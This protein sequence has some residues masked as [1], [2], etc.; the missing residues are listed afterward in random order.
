MEF[1][2]KIVLASNSPRRREL[3]AGLGIDF[4]VR[5]IGGIDESWPKELKGEDIPL[6]ISR[7]KSAPYKSQIA[8][9]ELVITAD[10]IV[11][12]DGKVLGKPA[13]KADA[14][15]MLRLISGRWHE[16]ITGVTLMTADRERSFAVTTKVKFC[17]LTEEEIL[18]YV[19]SGLPMDKAGAYGIQ[20]WIGF[21]GVEAIEGS[22]FNVVGLPVQRLY[23][24]LLLFCSQ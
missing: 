15:R 12:V 4:T 23:R 22:Y 17:N 20:E 14:V 2:Y 8:P 21:V 3:L 1:P 18:R 13:D 7:E 11:Y 19:E 6:Y 5:V 10:T 9:D 24:E 16:V